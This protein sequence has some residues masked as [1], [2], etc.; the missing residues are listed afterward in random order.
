MQKLYKKRRVA[1]RVFALLKGWFGEEIKAKKYIRQEY[2]L[3]LFLCSGFVN[4]ENRVGL[5]LA[6]G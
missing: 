3:K 4:L 1:E 6:L 5:F 2:A